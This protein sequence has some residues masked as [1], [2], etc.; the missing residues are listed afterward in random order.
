MN[1]S[2]PYLL[3]LI[4]RLLKC[5]RVVKLRDYV[6]SGDN[7]TVELENSSIDKLQQFTIC[8]RFLTPFLPT[9]FSNIQTLVFRS[10]L[11]MINAINLRDV[12]ERNIRLF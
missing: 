7:V 8:G 3:I 10:D 1:L 2:A 11:Y 9:T 5:V 6:T 4:A 12:L